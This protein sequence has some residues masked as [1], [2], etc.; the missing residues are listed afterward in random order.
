MDET[1]DRNE[2]NWPG[3]VWSVQEA[4]A[5]LSEV[6]RRAREEG[7]QVIG[8]TSPCVVVPEALWR[9][10]VSDRKPLGQWLVENSPRGDPL[11]LPERIEPGRSVPFE[12][13]S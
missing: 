2:H 13:E 5:K 4:K 7:P 3:R 11:T 6:L 12:D 1:V 9:E 10:N 8:T